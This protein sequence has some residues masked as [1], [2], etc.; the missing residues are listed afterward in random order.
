MI[1][2]A[3][4]GTRL[5]PL[6]YVMPKPVAPVLNRPIVAWIA[7]L[8]AEHDFEDVVTNLSYLPGQIRDV[9]GD[10]SAYGLRISYSEEPEPLGTAGGVGKV[11]D[12]L[13]ETDSF[14]IIS[15]DALTTIDLSAMREAHEA[16]V[17]RGAILTIA[18]KRVADTSQFGV[19]II[20]DDGRIQGFQEKPEPA[21]ALSDLANCG[22][23]MFKREIFDYFPP[24]DFK[25]PAGDD[26]QP[27]GFV[28]WAM[29]IFP[30]LLDGDIP[31]YSNEID[32][33]WNDIGSVGEFV[34]G[35]L[36]A[37]AGAVGIEPPAPAVE[38]GVYA[39]EGSDLDGVKVTPPVLIGEACQVGAGANLHGPVVVGDGC[40]VGAGAMLRD[41]VVLPGA[42]VPAGGL[43]V[44]GLYGVDEDRPLG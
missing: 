30:S 10:G 33:Y 34:Q 2:A 25:S 40:K 14:L 24:P 17:E 3:G 39:G 5:R 28:D 20:D 27:P 23:Y 1:L 32:A 35:N 42:Q 26:D 43:V 6:T 15:G 22:I 9:L 8:L 37:L 36:D 44:G 7:D 29:D 18:T 19:A 12:F 11:R 31:F 41:C 38:E 16:N 4:L 13:G 21:E